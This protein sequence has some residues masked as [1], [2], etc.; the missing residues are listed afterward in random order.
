MSKQKKNDG[1]RIACSGG[2]RFACRTA[3]LILCLAGF[4][5]GQQASDIQSLVASGNLDGMRWPNFSDYRTWLQKFY[6]PAAYAPAW[7][8]GGRP[9]PQVLPLIAVFKDA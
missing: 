6:E 1:M 4:S 3:V 7:V 2:V 8:Q 5:A 9:A